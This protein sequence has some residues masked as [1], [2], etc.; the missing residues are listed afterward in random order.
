MYIAA[1]PIG[2]A[3]G[4]GSFRRAS[5]FC[6]VVEFNTAPSSNAVIRM[7]MRAVHDRFNG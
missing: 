1:F 4:G 7:R 2:D 3:R 6:H 5:E